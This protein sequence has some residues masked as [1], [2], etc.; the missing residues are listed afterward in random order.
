MPRLDA[1]PLTS[2]QI[3]TFLSNVNPP[4]Q[5]DPALSKIAISAT[6]ADMRT[7]CSPTDIDAAIKASSPIPTSLGLPHASH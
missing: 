2:T 3:S 6:I 4:Y 5:S 1:R 7:W